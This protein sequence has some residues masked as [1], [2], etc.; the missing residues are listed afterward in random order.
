MVSRDYARLK[1]TRFTRTRF[2]GARGLIFNAIF[3]NPIV[4]NVFT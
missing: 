2:Q 4:P 3:F 1:I